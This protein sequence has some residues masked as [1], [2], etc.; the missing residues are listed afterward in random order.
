MF[1]AKTAAWCAAVH[2]GEE[3]LA[4]LDMP[5]SAEPGESFAYG[6]G[7]EWLGQAIEQATGV[8]FGAYVKGELWLVVSS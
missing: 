4:P 1:D 6:M 3:Q 5:L 8:S 2:P 7:L